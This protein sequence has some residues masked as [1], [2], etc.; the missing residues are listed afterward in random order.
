LDTWYT[1]GDETLDKT[2][3]D[4][5]SLVTG[6]DHWF[7][8]YLLP[9]KI[10]N[11][12]VVS[13]GGHV[14]FANEYHYQT[15]AQAFAV[16]CQTW[17]MLVLG[18]KRFDQS[19]ASKSQNAYGIW[20]ATK[21]LAGYYING[22]LAGV[23]YTTTLNK[24]GTL[25]K[26]DIWSGEWTWGAVFMT[27]KLAMEYKSKNPAWAAS[28]EADSI[29]MVKMMS[30]AAKTSKD[31]VWESGGLVQ[32]DGSYLYA[33]RRFFIPWGWYANPLGATSSTGWAVFNSWNYDPFALGGY[34]TDSTF[35][36]QQCKENPPDKAILTKLTAYYD[37]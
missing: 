17:G 23:G 15:G 25:D 16:D 35:W 12:T 30:Q 3:S 29:S 36:T 33:N 6:L 1:G 20:Q 10:D 22:E 18:S 7:A 11:E 32:I 37:Y 5:K 14:T 27:R 2:K 8:N 34:F 26:P 28:L 13:Q 4:V 24:N 31:G 21:K 9:A 19:Y